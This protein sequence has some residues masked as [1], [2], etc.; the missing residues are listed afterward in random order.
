[1]K[2][3]LKIYNLSIHES[4]NPAPTAD[5][6]KWTNILSNKGF[7]PAVEAMALVRQL[8]SGDIIRPLWEDYGFK[9]DVRGLPVMA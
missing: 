9:V 4:I 3:R 6:C 2:D 5:M 7:I 1:M 8:I